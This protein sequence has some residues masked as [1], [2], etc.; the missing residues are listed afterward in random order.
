MRTLDTPRRSAFSTRI[1]ALVALVALSCGPGREV[2]SGRELY[3][4]Y[5]C[6]ACHGELGDGR[7]PAAALSHTKP[8]D[9]RDL[10]AYRSSS[11]TEGIASTI[12]FGVAEGRTGMPAY[13]DIPKRERLAIAQYVHQLAQ[14]PR[15]V[16]VTDAWAPAAGPASTV[17][18]AYLTLANAGTREVAV[19][20]ITSDI[21]SVV[22]MHE[23]AMVNEMMTMR[24]IEKIALLPRVPVALEPG[25]A[26]LMLI[27]L[28]R[29]LRAGETFSLTLQFDDGSAQTVKAVI[30]SNESM[31][32]VT[33]GSE[34]IV[35]P[36]RPTDFTLVDHDGR[37]FRSTSLRGKP[38]LLFFGYTHC[39]DACPMTMSNLARAYRKAG[40]AAR[41]I[42]TLFVSVDPRDTPALLKNY[43]AYFGAIPAKGLTGSKA[44][45]DAVVRQLGARYEIRD[46]GSAAGPLVDHSLSVYLLGSDGRVKKKYLPNAHPDSIA[47]DM[48]QP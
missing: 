25:G 27:G 34:T 41:D 13:P 22:E 30:R 42:P 29:P 12:A 16:D 24:R 3:L 36:D 21:A 20:N 26:H 6:A 18:A 28:R 2:S 46:S 44:Q 14:Q 35:A 4:A 47:S 1:I 33:G 39:P 9:L 7:G 5:G 15:G 17:G 37:P 45:I 11:T 32:P 31:T 10:A 43:L 19:T 48:L 40:P 8:R 23:M 38:A